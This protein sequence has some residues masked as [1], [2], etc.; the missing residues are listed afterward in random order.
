MREHLERDNHSEAVTVQSIM[1][2]FWTIFS[3]LI[4]CSSALEYSN[5]WTVE[6]DGENGEADRLARKHGFINYGKIIDNYFSFIN[7]KVER[8]SKVPSPHLHKGLMS[9]PNV[10]MVYQQEMKYYKLLSADS[11]HFYSNDPRYDEM[12]YI[13]RD[14]GKSTYNVIDVWERNITGAGVV[15]AVVDVGID[16]EHPEIQANYDARASFDVNDNDANPFPSDSSGNS[17]IFRNGSNR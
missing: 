17:P 6:I 11:M 12:W 9:E 3:S 15:V 5:R 2:S 14:D 4:F 16:P 7:Q 1:F 8:V 13:N 10:K